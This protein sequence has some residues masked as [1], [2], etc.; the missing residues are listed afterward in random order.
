MSEATKWAQIVCSVLMLAFCFYFIISGLR[1]MKAN[2]E[3]WA[4]LE[5]DLK[6]EIAECKDHRAEHIKKTVLF[7]DAHGLMM[8]LGYDRP[9]FN[10]KIGEARVELLVLTLD[11]LKTPDPPNTLPQ[12]LRMTAYGIKAI[13]EEISRRQEHAN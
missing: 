8:L 10:K 11:V 1:R 5:Q 7:C 12:L 13:E 9:L 4:K 3:S 6:S 2:K